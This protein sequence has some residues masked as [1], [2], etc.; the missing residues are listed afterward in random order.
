M[1]LAV[2]W[3]VFPSK[4]IC[5]RPNPSV[6]AFGD[7]ALRE[8]TVKEVMIPDLIGWRP[9]KTRHQR[10]FTFCLCAMRKGQVSI[11]QESNQGVVCLRNPAL[12]TP[13]SQTSSRQTSEKIISCCLSPHIWSDLLLLPKLTT[14]I[15][16]LSHIQATQDEESNFKWKISYL[17]KSGLRCFY[18]LYDT[19]THIYTLT[20]TQFK[21]RC[22]SSTLSKIYLEFRG[23]W[24]VGERVTCE[25]ESSQFQGKWRG[26]TA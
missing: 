1:I 7:R 8:V 24:V 23:K 15:L 3:I 14:T 25:V 19:C 12:L 6:T 22:I 18:A 9:Y 13:R 17:R 5:R 16:V 20:Y 2:Y 11:P 21:R 26:G 10:E 4:C